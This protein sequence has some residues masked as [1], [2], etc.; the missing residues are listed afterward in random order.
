MK[1]L[2]ATIASAAVLLSACGGLSDREEKMVG[3]Y[4]IP[5]VSDSRPLIEL[6]ADRSAVVR[7]IRPGEL[8]YCVAGKWELSGD[9][10]VILT[11]PSSITI[12]EGDPALVG[13]VAPRVAYPVAACN[14]NTLTLER[15]G[16]TYDYHR[17]NE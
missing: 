4:Y 10:L 3:N 16:I 1:T 9:T 5:A 13:T 2:P 17:R 15:Q 8:S 12:E 14:E 6:G 11:D 7:A